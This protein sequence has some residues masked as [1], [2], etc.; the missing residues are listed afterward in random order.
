MPETAGD[1]ADLSFLPSREFLEALK[2]AGVAVPKP[3]WLHKIC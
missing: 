3:I 1:Q 2:E